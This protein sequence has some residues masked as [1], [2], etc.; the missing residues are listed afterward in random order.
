M[1]KSPKAVV[2]VDISE[3]QLERAV[4]KIKKLDHPNVILLKENDLKFKKNTFD[5]ISGVGVLELLDDPKTKIRR[6]F[7][8]LKKGGRFSFLSFGKSFG[9]PPPYDLENEEEVVDLFKGF[10]CSVIHRKGK[11]EVY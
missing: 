7:K 10:G 2:G 8:F 9:T 6:M 4:D 11:K 1:L 3:K 5:A